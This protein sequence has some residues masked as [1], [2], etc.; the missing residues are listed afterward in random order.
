MYMYVVKDLVKILT[1]RYTIE[2]TGEK[3]YKCDVCGKGFSLN[4]HLQTHIRTH[5]GN[6]PYKC[7][8]CGKGFSRNSNLQIHIRTHTGDTPYI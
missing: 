2:H 5:I 7:D 6:K 1:Y 8:I 4:H 3:P